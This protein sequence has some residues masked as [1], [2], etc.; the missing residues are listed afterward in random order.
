[1]SHVPVPPLQPRGRRLG[2]GI[3]RL[4]RRPA[5]SVGLLALAVVI[6][7]AHG[8]PPPADRASGV[9]VPVKKSSPV[10]PQ[11]GPLVLVSGSTVVRY[12]TNTRRQVVLALPASVVPLRVLTVGGIDV[13]LGRLPSTVPRQLPP[14]DRPEVPTS[15]DPAGPPAHTAAWVV[16]VGHTPIALGPAEA[17]VPSADG[18][19]VWLSHAGFAIRAVVLPGQ[20]PVRLRL[21]HGARLIADVPAGLVVTSGIVPGRLPTPSPTPTPT[22]SPSPTVSGLSGDT[23]DPTNDAPTTP[24]SRSS[25][26]DPVLL[27]TMIVRHTGA[28]RVVA[29]G[30]ALA[31]YRNVILIE[32]ADERLGIVHIAAALA[33][34]LPAV[35][36][37]PATTPAGATALASDQARQ[38]FWLPGLSA[39]DVTGPAAINYDS[40]TFAV[41]ARTHEH[42]RLMVGPVDAKSEGDIN[43][44]ALE[45]GPP[46]VDA[47][48]P[49]FTASGRIL[50]ARPDG[51]IVYYLPGSKQGALLGPDV[52]GGA[53]AV[54]QG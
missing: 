42:V 34:V 3:V 47:A 23:H 30:E 7:V 51:K 17:V 28:V 9:S 50:V 1:M 15:L 45:G 31:A 4:V 11:I 22:P 14:E 39:V 41:L 20:R 54:A 5:V 18:H 10:P 38:P 13:V 53:V 21:P 26:L 33:P 49:T 36:G 16:R 2:V 19:S 40:N 35:G 8:Q 24:A 37:T 48:P 46:T 52:P 29:E 44:V 6:S 43:T 12:D 27:S 32:R 25:V